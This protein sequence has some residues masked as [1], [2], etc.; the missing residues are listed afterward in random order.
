M[1]LAMKDE[2]LDVSDYYRDA[3]L[4][5]SSRKRKSQLDSNNS[6]EQRSSTGV[7]GAP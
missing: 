6:L 1:H 2:A 7:H 4:F 5:R 3:Q